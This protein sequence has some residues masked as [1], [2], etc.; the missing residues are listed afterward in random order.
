MKGITTCEDCVIELWKEN[1]EHCEAVRPILVELEKEGYMFESYNI[2]TVSGRK[3][4]EEYF[5]EINKNSKE[6]GYDEGYIYT[7]TFINP[8]TRK[9]LAFTDRAPTK[10]ELMKLVEGGEMI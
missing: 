2:E 5:L 9:V 3:I 6:K 1:C 7:P 8:K 4:L 10:E